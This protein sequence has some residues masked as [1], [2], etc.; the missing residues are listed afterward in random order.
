MLTV[1][2]HYR[3]AKLLL[4]G[5]SCTSTAIKH[6]PICQSVSH[7]EELNQ[8]PWSKWSTCVSILGHTLTYQL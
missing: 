5:K 2:V 3:V 4:L 8:Q 1:H 6:L 7:T